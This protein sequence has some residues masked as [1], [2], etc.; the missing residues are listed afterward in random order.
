MKYTLIT[1]ASKGIGKSIAIEAANRGMNLLLVARSQDLLDKLAEELSKKNVSVKT[2][3]VDLMANDA[4]KKVF[5]FAK[6][7]GLDINMLVNN[8]GMGFY[9]VFDECPLEKHLEVMHLNMDVCVK[10]AY[11]FLQSSNPNQ[12][13]Y[14]LNTVSTGAYQPVPRMGIYC[15]TK[16]FMLSFTRAL[17]HEL[18]GKKVYVTALCPGP[19]ESDFFAPAQMTRVVEKNPQFMMGSDKVA[20]VGLNALLRNKSVAIPGIQN[21]AGA[22]FARIIPH[23]VI[24]PVIAKFFKV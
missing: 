15:A 4:P 7:N 9:G 5:E 18:K 20:K 2:F 1:G 22:F 24:V 21:Q 16:S 11:G 23:D 17:R 10:M 19:T 12:Q 3:A 13:R 8:A 6:Q 14:I